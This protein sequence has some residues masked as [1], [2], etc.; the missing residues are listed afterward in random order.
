[1]KIRNQTSALGIIVSFSTAFSFAVGDDGRNLLLIG[2]MIVGIPF[3]LIVHFPFF[4]KQEI[5]IYLLVFYM[6]LLNV[7][8]M[9]SIRFNSFFYTVL[10]LLTF[11]C[12]TRLISKNA[13]A[14]QQYIKVLR[15]LIY[16]YCITLIL[17]QFCSLTGLPIINQILS[18]E[19]DFKFNALSPEPSHSARIL[20]LLAYFFLSCKDIEQHKTYGLN[21]LWR[22]DKKIIFAFLYPML[23][24]GSATA[25]MFLAILSIKFVNWQNKIGVFTVLLVGIFIF[26]F[27]ESES[28]RRSI[29]FVEAFLTFDQEKLIEADHSGSLRVLPGFIY[30]EKFNFFDIKYWLGGGSGFSASFLH[31]LLPGVSDETAYSGGFFPGFLLDYGL[32]SGAIFLWIMSVFCLKH[33]VSMEILI[34]LAIIPSLALN[35]QILWLALMLLA[36]NKYF[37]KQNLNLNASR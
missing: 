19:D 12:Y 7:I 2:L 34:S 32:L 9:E 21:Q 30:I 5:P 18:V 36:T 31:G 37:Y 27:V 35:T 16:G 11:I 23:T 10:F 8:N 1:M 3:L 13:L 33:L 6:A 4:R 20:T 14:L 22:Y 15:Y 24:M 28:M 26:Q 17:Q 25:F 29:T